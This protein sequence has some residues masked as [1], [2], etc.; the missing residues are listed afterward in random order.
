MILTITRISKILTE[1]SPLTSAA[2]T[3][4]SVAGNPELTIIPIALIISVISILPSA[5]KSPD[6]HSTS[7]L[8][9]F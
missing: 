2:H 7:E 8:S 3:S 4:S 5:F 9:S 1:A 6:I